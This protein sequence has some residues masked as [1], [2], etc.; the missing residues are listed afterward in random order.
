MAHPFAQIEYAH[1]DIMGRNFFFHLKFYGFR[2]S[3]R[4]SYE[5]NI[6]YTWKGLIE[7]E[8]LWE[9]IIISFCGETKKEY[10][11]KKPSV[12][13]SHTNK[14]RRC[15]LTKNKYIVYLYTIMDKNFELKDLKSV[16]YRRNRIKFI[17]M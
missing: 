5:L 14:R 17:Y 8:K 10:I 3:T 16:R 6:F 4:M 15:F 13:V 11:H 7:I 2:C 12:V 1:H 9:Q